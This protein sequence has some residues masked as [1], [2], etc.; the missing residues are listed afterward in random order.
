MR[1]ITTATEACARLNSSERLTISEVRALA[2]ALNV[3]LDTGSE[4]ADK[5]FTRAQAQQ[6]LRAGIQTRG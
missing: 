4:P 3:R 5:I 2:V 6:L 1:Q